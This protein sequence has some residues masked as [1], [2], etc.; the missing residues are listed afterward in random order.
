MYDLIIIGG[1]ITGAG[2]ALDA[3]ARGLKTLL[4]EKND[5]AFGTSSRSTK[6]IHGGLR[7]LKNMEFGLVRELGVERAVVHHLAPHLT[8]PEKMLTPIVKNGTYG[9][10]LT[11][12]GIAL[13]D[14]LAGVKKEERRQML[15]KKETQLAEPLLRDD[16]LEGAALYFE[17]RTDDA[18]LTIE[19]IKTAVKYG[20]KCL[21]Y[22]K[23]TDFIIE[24]DKIAGIKCKD[25]I[26]GQTVEFKATTIV[27]AA[28]P[29]VDEV[30]IKGEVIAGKR[31]HLTKGVHLVVKKE[32][33]PVKQAVYFDVFDGRMVFVIPR[34]EITYFGTTDTDYK[35]EIDEPQISNDDKTY[36]LKAVNN[37]FP[38]THFSANDI[39]SGWVGLRPLIH[40]DGKSSSEI[41]RKDEVFISS[42]GLISI[43]GGKLTGYRKMA[44]RVVDLV[45]KTQKRAFVKTNT[46]NIKLCGGEFK[47][48]D[49]V[50]VF[51]A[52]IEAELWPYFNQ[53]SNLNAFRLVHLYGT[54]TDEILKIFFNNLNQSNDFQKT[55]LLSEYEFCQKNEFVKMP[56]DF[57][58]RRSGIRYFNPDLES[59]FNQ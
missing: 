1:G 37:F 53:N 57:I 41:S 44:E 12:I 15:S 47:D 36:L 34:G 16:I 49:E 40:E 51:I 9:K 29:W 24:N 31:L 46:K 7:Y 3:S 59:I 38:N 17:Y 25:V 23:V 56:E 11:S 54:Q 28:G 22:T 27:N 52:R 18:R 4:V 14:Y 8:V 48:F 2:I 45:F 50:K 35:G 39:I 42:K 30:R 21:N 55:L 13:Y 26:S 10:W 6:L 33:L 43:A 20:A 19:I 5:F 58:I 32:K